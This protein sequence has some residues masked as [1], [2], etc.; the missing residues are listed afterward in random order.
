MFGRLDGWQVPE[1]RGAMPL[2][3]GGAYFERT[4]DLMDGPIAGQF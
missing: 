3:Q 1:L 2:L 4:I